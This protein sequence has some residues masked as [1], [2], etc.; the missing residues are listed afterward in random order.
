VA[1]LDLSPGEFDLYDIHGNVRHSKRALTHVM[2]ILDG[3]R[4]DPIPLPAPPPW[5]TLMDRE[6][7]NG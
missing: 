6:T 4:W 7:N 3:K 1:V 5:V 2:T